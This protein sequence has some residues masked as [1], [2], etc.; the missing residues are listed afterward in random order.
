M[1]Q[2]GHK[3]LKMCFWPIFGPIFLNFQRI[4]LILFLLFKM[5]KMEKKINSVFRNL[6]QI[7]TKIAA[8][9][10]LPARGPFASACYRSGLKYSKHQFSKRIETFKSS[11]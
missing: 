10:T 6:Y 5:K 1:K 9:G 7:E 3:M 8:K 4:F 11:N 2:N